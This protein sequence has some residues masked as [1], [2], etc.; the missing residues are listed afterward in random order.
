MNVSRAKQ[1]CERI[2]STGYDVQIDV[3]TRAD[4]VTRD[5]LKLF[6]E[7]GVTGIQFGLESGCEE[8]LKTI[9]KGVT[10]DKVRR[11]VEWAKE[12]GIP[13]VAVTFI[14]GLP[15]E[16]YSMALKTIEFVRN[17]NVNVYGVYPLLLEPGSE[18]FEKR[19]EYGIEAKKRE[20][21]Y[22]VRKS[23]FLTKKSI[24]KL[25]ARAIKIL[26]KDA[27]YEYRIK[28]NYITAD[29]T[30]KLVCGRTLQELDGVSRNLV[31]RIS[32]LVT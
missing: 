6:R 10:P 7:A 25:V 21:I 8:V 24:D 2:I 9:K 3:V 31:L 14:L 32:A 13:N 16:T 5:L 22:L 29:M 30:S 28:G 18:L 11:A 19:K 23:T 1:I 20:G 15:N 12:A 26:G 4:C 27:N 17:L